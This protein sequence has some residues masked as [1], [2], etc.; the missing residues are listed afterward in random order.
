MDNTLEGCETGLLNWKNL[1]LWIIKYLSRCAVLPGTRQLT[2]MRY[3]V[4]LVVESEPNLTE[5]L[6]VGALHG[7]RSYVSLAQ[8]LGVLGAN[9]FV[10]G[11]RPFRG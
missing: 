6:T 2:I 5:L 4:F 9:P 11:G 10:Q 7:C 3:A 1:G 8:I